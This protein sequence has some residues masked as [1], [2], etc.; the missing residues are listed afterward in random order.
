MEEHA[1]IKPGVLWNTEITSHTK[2]IYVHIFKC[3]A[4]ILG[5]ATIVYAIILIAQCKIILNYKISPYLQ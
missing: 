5:L 1:R 3:L 4:P 2:D